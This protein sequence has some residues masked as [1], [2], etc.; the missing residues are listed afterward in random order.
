MTE[1]T[2]LQPL[3]M[4]MTV[5]PFFVSSAIVGVRIWKKTRE[6]KFAT[7][8]VFPEKIVDIILTRRR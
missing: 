3:N 8:I 4:F 6:R 7:G 2:G 5:L 1:D